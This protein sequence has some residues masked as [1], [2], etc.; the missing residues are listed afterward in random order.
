MDLTRP[1]WNYRLARR[2]H[3][4]SCNQQAAC[5]ADGE[6]ISYPSRDSHGPRC[7][8][9]S[10]AR[11]P[12]ANIELRGRRGRKRNC[13][14]RKRGKSSSIRCGGSGFISPRVRTKF[15]ANAPPFDDIS[16]VTL[17]QNAT[18]SEVIESASDL[19]IPDRSEPPLSFSRS[20]PLNSARLKGR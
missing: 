3:P 10:L 19:E 5:L 20:H 9:R 6:L 1:K 2:S 7:N 11:M 17:E 8:V 13:R 16:E 18:K 4:T 14:R 12:N 15:R